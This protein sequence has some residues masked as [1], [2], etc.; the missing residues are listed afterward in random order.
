MEAYFHSDP[1]IEEWVD[2][3]TEKIFIVCRLTGDD[4]EVE[5][6][7]GCQIV[8]KVTNVLQGI[9]MFPS[10]YLEEGVK[11][12]LEQRLPDSR[13]INNFPTFR[14]TMNK[15]L[16]E[17][18]VR[19]INTPNQEKLKSIAPSIKDT[20]EITK[21][22]PR[23]NGII[24]DI[25]TINGFTGRSVNSLNDELVT[26]RAIPVLGSLVP[27]IP[28]KSYGIIRKTQVPEEADRLKYVLS[29]IFPNTS[30]C[31][32]L[33]LMGQTLLAQVEDILICLHNPEQT[34]QV[35]TLSKEGWKV[36][37]CSSDDLMFPRRLERGIRQIQRI[38]KKFKNG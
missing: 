21:E 28:V 32:N 3:I 23:V 38:G 4:S 12:L 36:F 11:Q 37:L 24:N 20:A 30:V 1:R 27:S 18:M 26:E 35:E 29:K 5:F 16:A 6:Q 33:N 31:W 19:A 25:V 10:E 9:S 8:T 15:M 14:D 7:R 17:G 13:V 22:I 34:C 2:Q